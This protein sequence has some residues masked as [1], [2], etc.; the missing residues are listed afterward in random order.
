M[1]KYK[2]KYQFIPLLIVLFV[3]LPLL[4]LSF[5]YNNSLKP[6]EEIEEDY[7]NEEIIDR[8]LPVINTKKTIINPFI[9]PSVKEGKLYYDYK[10]DE[11]NQINSIVIRDNTY[12]QNTGID[13]VSDT[14]FD[15]VAILEGTISSI[16]EEDSLGKTIEIKHDNG[17]I[18]IYQS[19]SDISVKKGEIVTQGQVIGRS[20]ENEVDKELGNHLHFEIYN[21]GKS[22]N[23]NNYLNKEVENYEDN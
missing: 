18:S 14:P 21:T 5:L 9:D 2:L 22:V 23:P 4:V 3:L 15:V 8:S 19:L 16:K 20:G 11:E 17:L 10:A 1:K 6:K 7:V 13:Y 12:T